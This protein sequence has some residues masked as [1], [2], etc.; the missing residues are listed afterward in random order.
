M[1]TG[2]AVAG[3]TGTL[4]DAFQGMPIQGKFL[5]KTGTL[6]NVKTLSGLLPVSDTDAVFAALMLNGAGLADQGNYRPL[7]NRLANAIGSYPDAPPTDDLG[8][9]APIA[10]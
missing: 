7:W 6:T 4:S 3:K 9:V 5:G 2:L 10:P 8:V 1:R